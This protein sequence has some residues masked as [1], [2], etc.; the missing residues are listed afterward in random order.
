MAAFYKN[1]YSYAHLSNKTISKATSIILQKAFRIG[2]PQRLAEARSFLKQPPSSPF[3]RGN[4]K[5]AGQAGMTKMKYLSGL[6]CELL[7]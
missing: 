4:K 2:S 3:I 1:R 7:K 6:T 5:D